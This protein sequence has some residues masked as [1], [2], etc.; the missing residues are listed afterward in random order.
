MVSSNL[1]CFVFTDLP[2]ELRNKI[3]CEVFA[4]SEF[5]LHLT[6]KGAG[7]AIKHYQPPEDVSF[8][9]VSSQIYEEALPEL[10]SVSELWLELCELIADNGYDI[11]DLFTSNFTP[12]LLKRCMPLIKT[13]ICMPRDLDT[14]IITGFTNFA[15][16]E[17]LH[18]RAWCLQDNQLGVELSDLQKKVF[19][20]PIWE[21]RI[22]SNVQGLL[23]QDF[24]PLASIV[25]EATGRFKVH[26]RMFLHIFEDLEEN[27]GLG[28]IFP[29][30]CIG[31]VV[32]S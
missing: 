22:M 24:A 12:N 3:Y 26:E 9:R 21:G 8:L 27:T 19:V 16:L 32:S 30:L 11:T 6:S 23:D 29:F 4:N 17:V 13:V 20:S 5:S 18:L 14:T 25:R 7:A 1:R 28:P 15:A 10:A 2:R 31:R